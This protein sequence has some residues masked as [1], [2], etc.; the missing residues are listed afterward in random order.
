M[1]QLT[2]PNMPIY[3]EWLVNCAALLQMA[4]SGVRS[5]FCNAWDARERF[6]ALKREIL[7]NHGHAAGYD[8]QRIQ[9]TCWRCDG[10]GVVQ[11][12]SGYPF[13][14]GGEQDYCQKCLGTGIFQ[15]RWILLNRYSVAGLIFHCPAGDFVPNGTAPTIKGLIEHTPHPQSW[16]AYRVLADGRYSLQERCTCAAAKQLLAR[17]RRDGSRLPF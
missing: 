6:Y 15:D 10:T 4:N 12:G 14:H 9:K 8:I 7:L 16:E 2:F 13:G 1:I 3:E 11:L 17:V 5:W